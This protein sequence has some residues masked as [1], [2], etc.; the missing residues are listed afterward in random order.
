MS[1]QRLYILTGLS[2]AGKT[3]LSNELASRLGLKQA[4]VDSEIIKGGY[5]V[6]K[7]DQ[8]DWNAVYSRAY[9]KLELYL[10]KGDS[11]V[12]DGASLTRHERDNLRQI[13]SK[14]ETPH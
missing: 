2:Y 3:T 8:D 7:M 4:S 10:S 13:A 12:F 14:F 6:G 5:D 9:D 11:V 1:N